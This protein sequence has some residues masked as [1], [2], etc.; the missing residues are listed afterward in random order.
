MG[1]INFYILKSAL[2]IFLLLSSV[3]LHAQKNYAVMVTDSK[4]GNAIVGADIKIISTGAISKTSESGNVVMLISSE[5]SL[6]ITAKGY[7]ERKLQMANQ[8]IAL[9]IVLDPAPVKDKIAVKPK[10]KKNLKPSS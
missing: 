7:K 6:L 3:L 1:K 10:K 5:D 2:L 8:F 4:T 9:S